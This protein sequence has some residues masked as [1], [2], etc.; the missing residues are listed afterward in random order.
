MPL[1]ATREPSSTP[2]VVPGAAPALA[3]AGVGGYLF[4]DPQESHRPTPTDGCHQALSGT[5]QAKYLEKALSDAGLPVNMA[6]LA[7][8]KTAI[9]VRGQSG[10]RKRR[11]TR[12]V[13]FW[14]FLETGMSCHFCGCLLKPHMLYA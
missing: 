13:N 1:L 4:S 5:D 10:S 3:K 14:V 8:F 12:V 9:E 7:K 2:P 11:G 6:D